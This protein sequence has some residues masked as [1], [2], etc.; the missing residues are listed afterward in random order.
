MK[1]PVIVVC[2]LIGAVLVTSGTFAGEDVLL[3]IG[4][5]LWTI[6]AGVVVHAA[7]CFA[8]DAWEGW[9]LEVQKREIRKRSLTP[10]T[11]YSRNVGM[12]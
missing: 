8:V 6:A 3:W 9:R 12:R 4:I 1:F 10:T 2:T 5:A 7:V 11:R